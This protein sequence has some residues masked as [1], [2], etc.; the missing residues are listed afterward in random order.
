MLMRLI[1]AKGGGVFRKTRWN[2]HTTEWQKRSLLHAHILI[3]LR[4]KIQASEIDRVIRAELPD[5][6]KDPALFAVICK[7]IIHGPYG[8]LNPNSSCM[9]DRKC[10]NR[11]PRGFLQ[12]TQ[13]GHDVYPLYRC[14]QSEDG[15][16][17]TTL[18]PAP[19]LK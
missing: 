12:E 2:M 13:T 14:R 16:F 4:E 10:T 6:D 7:Q 1:T 19:T 15:G 5:H 17:E 18:N 11:F 9:Q 3:W 8:E